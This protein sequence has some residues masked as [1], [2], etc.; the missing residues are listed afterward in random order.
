MIANISIFAIFAAK[1]DNSSRKSVIMDTNKY[2]LEG[3]SVAIIDDHEVVLEGFRSFMVKNG[4]SD[5]EA[6]SDTQS[7]LNR[8]R[9]RQF[10]VYIVDVELPDMDVSL[11]IDS[12]RASHTDARILINTMHEEA[13]VV[14]KLTDKN[15]DGVL[16]KSGQLEQLLEAIPAVAEGHKY[17]SKDFKRT[18]NRLL[19]QNDIPS[20]RELDVLKRIAKG[21]STKEISA[22]LFISENTVENHRKNLFRKLKAHNMADLIMKAIAAGHIDPEEI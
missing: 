10:N 12:I 20:N 3:I 1:T 14:S 5:V 15:V 13:W 18:Q 2:R 17:F 6:F 4:I 9:S 21:Y 22:S 8:M 16:Y 11:L 7:L 19:Q